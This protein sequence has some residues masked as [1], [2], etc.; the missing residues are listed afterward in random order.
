[1]TAPIDDDTGLT[2]TGNDN[3]GSPK[4]G[5]FKATSALT[6]ASGIATVN[7]TTTMQPGDNFAVAA[8]T[9]TTYLGTVK[10][11]GTSLK[12]N[13]N[14]PI[15][16]TLACSSSAV[17]ACRTEMLTVWRRLHLE[18]DSM[19]SANGNNVTGNISSAV[20]ITNGINTLTVNPVTPATPL[21]L[22]RF[23]N[24][25]LAIIDSA[26]KVKSFK[27]V[28]YDATT[29]PPTDANTA[30]TVTIN[31]TGTAYSVAAGQTF[32]LYDDDDF[33]DDDD[34]PPIRLDGDEGEPIVERTE[35]FAAMRANDD[36]N[37]ADQDC[38][39]YG[40]AYIKPEYAWARAKGFNQTNVPFDLNVETITTTDVSNYVL[41]H[42]NSTATYEKDN[43]WMAYV[44]VAYQG[45][46]V[47][48]AD[49]RQ[50]DST[51][52]PAI[53][54]DTDGIGVIDDLPASGVVPIGGN[55]SLKYL[56]AAR[57]YEIY[58]ISLGDDPEWNAGTVPHE[59][60]HQM[61]LNGD[62]NGF[63]IMSSSGA[64]FNFVDRH[65]NI[66]RARTKSPGQ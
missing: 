31:N 29:T 36:L 1:M 30:T 41:P 14:T 48:D 55:A 38:N 19:A 12:D 27:L 65:L 66:L 56:E 13:A 21:E 63:G 6:D 33:N 2:N 64:T 35:T 15:P 4:S 49:G 59:V 40:A 5:T 17:N 3:R 54:G 52:E 61:G 50:L 51:L 37:C 16:A 20:T 53:G 46:V 11:D 39:I 42:R 18:V 7:F 34:A 22:N 43:F 58:T 28:G 8:S 44:M 62:A 24:G 9:N 26:G 25:R 47:Q 57:D 60:G 45:N 10:I 23:E 32:T